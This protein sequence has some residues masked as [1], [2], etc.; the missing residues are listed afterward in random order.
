MVWV[1]LWVGLEA[2]GQG[3]TRVGNWPHSWHSSAPS[4]FCLF[5]CFK[6]EAARNCF[7]LSDSAE[8]RLAKP[9]APSQRPPPAPP[10][11]TTLWAILHLSGPRIYWTP[12][13]RRRL[14]LPHPPTPALQPAPLGR[15]HVAAV[16]RRVDR[17]FCHW[18]A[19][20]DQGGNRILD[21]KWTADIQLADDETEAEATTP[22]LAGWA[23]PRLL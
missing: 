14:L 20:L 13:P 2:A 9:S 8:F 22:S 11:T 15:P 10:P 5:V 7:F 4:H 1:G 6:S 21:A 23:A 12:G 3:P 16:G 18:Q 19:R 17:R